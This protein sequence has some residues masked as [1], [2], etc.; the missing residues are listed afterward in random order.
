M[1]GLTGSNVAGGCGMRE[2]PRMR[3]MLSQDVGRVLWARP[4]M[5]RVWRESGS[6][7][8]GSGMERKRKVS[9]RRVGD[10]EKGGGTRRHERKEEEEE[11]EEKEE[12]AKK[13]GLFDMTLSGSL[14]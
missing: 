5:A 4:G 10:E 1:S 9:R 12:E 2:N 14:S 6:W 11:E 7:G 13:K 8:Q 3:A